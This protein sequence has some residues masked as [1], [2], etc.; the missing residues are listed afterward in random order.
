MG[1]EMCIRD[2]QRTILAWHLGWSPAQEAS[3]DGWIAPYLAQLLTD[4]YSATRQVAYRSIAQLPGF[5][6]FTYDYV[7]SGPEIGRKA[8]EAIQRWMGVPGPVPNGY[9][10]L[11][12]ADG[13]VNLGEW[14]R[15][16]GQRDERP[17]TIRE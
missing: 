7:A 6:G 14:T 8:D 2:R 13:Q 17:L 11:I 3:G 15:L 10:L 4:P 16:L 9:H 5:G 12:N 1:S